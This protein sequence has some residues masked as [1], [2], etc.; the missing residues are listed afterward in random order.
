MAETPTEL[1]QTARRGFDAGITRPL[2]WRRQQLKQLDRMLAENAATIEEAVRADLGKHLLEAHMTEI[3]SVRTEIALTI[4]NLKRWTK[5][6]GVPVPLPLR[7]ATGRIHRQPLGT[8][9]VIAPWN[10]PVRLLL[11]PVAGAIAAG[12]AVVAKPSEVSSHTSAVLARLF[13]KYL[14]QRAVTLVE[15][16]VEETTE[17]LEQR[18]DHIFYTGNGAVG[19]IVM[20]AAVRHLTPVTLELGGKSPVYVDESADIDATA[21]W[22]AWGKLLNTGQ[23]CVAPDYVLAPPTVVPKLVDALRREITVLYGDEPRTSPDYGRIISTRHVDRLAGLLGGTGEIVIGGES[24]RDEKYVAPT[25]LT[26]VS[27][28]DPVMG[29]EIFGPILPIV[30]VSGSDEAINVIN[31]REKPLALYLFAR[32]AAV[33]DAFLARTTSGSMGINAD[34]IQLGAPA[35]PFGGVGESGTGA[36]HGEHT[37][38]L[39]SHERAVLRK[40]RG[41]NLTAMGRPPFTARKERMLRSGS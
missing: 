33:R 4:K 26:G 7:P 32:S 8:V 29:E 3:N 12:N 17:L 11:I 40:L 10:Y 6:R 19:R 13:P 14:D 35:L 41:P 30:T 37:V 16:G 36:Y 5:P 21:A 31:S 1:A 20:A 27:L 39:F 38:R 18:W 9:L 34:M 15:G 24:D 23:T 2:E 22:L 28:D 25:V